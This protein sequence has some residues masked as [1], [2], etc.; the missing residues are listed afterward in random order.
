[1]GKTSPKFIVLLFLFL[2][3]LPL[4]LSADVLLKIDTASTSVLRG[5]EKE[6]FRV[7]MKHDAFI[8]ATADDIAQAE[9]E[10]AD[11]AYEILDDNAWQNPYYLLNKPV[12]DADSDVVLHA[13]DIAI[14][15]ASEADVLRLIADGNDVVRLFDQSLPLDHQTFNTSGL[16]KSNNGLS[17]SI[18]RNLPQVAD[19]TFRAY[20]QRLQDFKTRYCLSDSIDSARDW[21]YDRFLEFGYTTVETDQFIG[22]YQT[23]QYNVFAIKPGTQGTDRVIVV[24]GH[25]DSIVFD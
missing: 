3:L 18:S 1:M 19:S 14:V 8:I 4:T 13:D 17:K 5:M 25:Y 9:L 21:L 24:G 20:V 7:C 16:A 11:I 22:P 15:R 10:R 2:L 23:T 6:H 12:L